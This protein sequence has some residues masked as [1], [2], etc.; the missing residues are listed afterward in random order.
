[1]YHSKIDCHNNIKVW[2][3]KWKEVSES[4]WTLRG[5]PK[6]HSLP[7]NHSWLKKDALPKAHPTPWGQPTTKT[8][9]WRHVKT[10]AL[11]PY[12]EHLCT[13]SQAQVSCKVQWGLYW[14]CIT[15][16]LLLLPSLHPLLAPRCR[17]QQWSSRNF[18]HGNFY[19][20]FCFP[21][22]Y[23]QHM[24]SQGKKAGLHDSSSFHF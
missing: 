4:E 2:E 20:R 23:L 9:Q 17:F 18:P 12:W 6:T 19:L 15:A 10:W 3:K 21:G 7:S 8:G 13:T 11:C 16:Q 5:T 22:N 14:D 24:A 1:M